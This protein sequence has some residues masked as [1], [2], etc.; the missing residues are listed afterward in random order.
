MGKITK[1]E[2][3]K[4]VPF[5]WVRLKS[6]WDN[7]KSYLEM[8]KALDSHYNEDGDDPTKS[9]RAKCSVAMTK[10]IK[11]DGK[12]VRFKRR[13]KPHTD[14]VSKPKATATKQAK[15]P[16]TKPKVQKPKVTAKKL[17]KVVPV[18][19]SSPGKPTQPTEV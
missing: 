13:S 19:P 6:M 17:A 10:G 11:L 3:G 9:I 1:K 16:T 5:N 8:A 15:K 18:S 14:T 7:G 4:R 2:A 12:L